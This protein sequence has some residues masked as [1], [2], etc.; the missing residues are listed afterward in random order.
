MSNG[1]EL[2]LQ[3]WVKSSLPT[4]ASRNGAQLLFVDFNEERN[5]VE[6][7]EKDRYSV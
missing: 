4:S 6:G 2:L 5:N 1:E 7:T 3:R